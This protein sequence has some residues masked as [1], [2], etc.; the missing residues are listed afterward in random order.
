M[1]ALA[2]TRRMT[3]ICSSVSGLAL[4][5]ALPAYGK[6]A[7]KPVERG[8]AHVDVQK[9]S[10]GFTITQRLRVP[11]DVRAD[12]EAAAHM[13]EQGRYEPAIA[14]LLKVTERAPTA[15][16]AHIDLGM[17]YARTGDLDR[18]EASLQQAL[19]LT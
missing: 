3:G 17:A 11:T 15:T 7:S 6:T 16:A 8:A 9:D 19:E 5:L 18:A 1:S 4:L 12:Y 14:L 2:R 10:G 13:L